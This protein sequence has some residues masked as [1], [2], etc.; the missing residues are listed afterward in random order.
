MACITAHGMQHC[1]VVGLRS[2][3]GSPA[4]LS[5]SS[6]GAASSTPTVAGGDTRLLPY[7][8]P[9]N[10]ASPACITLL[11]SRHLNRYACQSRINLPCPSAAPRRRSTTTRS[12]STRTT[13]LSPSTTSQ[14]MVRRSPTTRHTG[15]TTH[16]STSRAPS[17]TT[18]RLVL[19]LQTAS[20]RLSH[21]GLAGAV[22]V[23]AAIGHHLAGWA[24]CPP[25]RAENCWRCCC[26]RLLPSVQH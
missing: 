17:P 13:S 1:D 7:Q 19:S 18:L 16:P 9:N 5:G 4:C 2:S 21:A 26:C 11:C 14:S 25:A 24:R 10:S 3:S 6:L 12:Q 22:P 20:V 8:Q 23:T 15:S